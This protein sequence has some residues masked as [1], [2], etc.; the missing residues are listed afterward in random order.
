MAATSPVSRD[1]EH[2]EIARLGPPA[3]ED[4]PAGRRAGELG[5]F[6]TGVVECPACRARGAVRA[7][8]ITDR[9][10]QVRGHR[11]EDLWTARC[12]G[13]VIEVEEGRIAV[14]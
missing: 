7:G 14:R 3:R 9:A 11:F 8:G 10:A 1:S 5:Y 13:G 6:F 2:R 4:D 12:R